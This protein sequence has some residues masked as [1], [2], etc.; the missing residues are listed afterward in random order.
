MRSYKLMIDETWKTQYKEWKD[1]KPYQIRLLE[2]GPISQSQ[3]WILNSM[4]CEWLELKKRKD[5]EVSFPINNPATDPW[6]L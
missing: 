1:L 2:D 4:W 6:Q 5:S 3:A